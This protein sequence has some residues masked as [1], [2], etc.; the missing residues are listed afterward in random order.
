MLGQRDV[1]GDLTGFVA[2]GLLLAHSVAKAGLYWLSGLVA[3][4]GLTDWAALRGHPLMIFA[5]VTF[6][7]LLVGLPPFPGFYAKWE[8]A[9]V[10]AGRRPHGA[11]GG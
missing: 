11:A 3:G 2:L 9:R 10:L 7:C 4:R 8:L 1:L 5:F 6:I